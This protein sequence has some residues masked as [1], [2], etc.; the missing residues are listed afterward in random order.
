MNHASAAESSISES[1]AW[2]IEPRPRELSSALSSLD[3]RA[4]RADFVAQD[5]FIH[6]PALLPRSAVGALVME[7]NR[8]R[9]FA[10]RARV[11]LYKKSGSVSYFRLRE[12]APSLVDLY[13]SHAM[14]SFLRTLTSAD[15]RLC[16]DDDPHACA[17]YV[18]DQ[19]GDR[20]GFHYDASHYRG[21]RYTVL[22]GLV[23][24]SSSRLRCQLH[25]DDPG[26]ARE[27]EVA[28]SPGSVVVFNGDRL[29]HGV[30]PVAVGEERVVLSLEYVTDARMSPIRRVLSRVKDAMAYFGFREVLRGSARS[31]SDGYSGGL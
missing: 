30:S 28:T 12:H 23:D 11:P 8:A 7:A 19:P 6:L 15:L 16:P 20:I 29:H 3:A 24:R 2:N 4:V 21:R 22:V 1:A 10:V 27:V 25:R 17:L 18:Y 5:E 9:P 14:L 26:R 13:R 31:R